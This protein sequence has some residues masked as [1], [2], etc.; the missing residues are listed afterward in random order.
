MV[1]GAIQMIYLKDDRLV[2]KF[3]E[4]HPDAEMSICFQ[5][6]MRIPDDG[7]TYPLPPGLGAFPIRHVD[8]FSKNLPSKWVER[9]GVMIPM[10]QSEALWISFN[11]SYISERYF[12]AVKISTGK[13]S[14]ITGKGWKKGLNSKPQD[15]AVIPDQP[16]L[17]GYC[18]E[19][20][21]IRQFVAMPLGAGYTA[22]EQITG[23]AEHGG[24][25]IEVF[26]MKRKVYEDLMSKRKKQM[27]EDRHVLYCA[28]G[29]DMGLAPGGKMRQEIYEDKYGLDAWDTSVS[30]RCFIHI[31]NSLAWRMITGDN[32][33]TTPLTSKEYA[34]SGLPWF[35]YYGGDLKALNGAKE[36]KNLK[37]IMEKA[38]EKGDKPLPENES[39]SYDRVIKLGVTEKGQVREGE[40]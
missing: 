35:D 25:Q 23:L 22:E 14:A 28:P 7:G 19:K 1:K 6:T 3:P 31:V 40:F 30:S 18:V 9:G 8:D 4:I 2:F 15:Y 36:L 13:I 34:A 10:Y 39:V 29:P 5:R 17:D 32:P 27:S 12:F 24:L 16:W 38:E 20:G 33:P 21:I 11:G 37:S 26:P